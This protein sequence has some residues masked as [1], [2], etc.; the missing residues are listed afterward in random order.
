MKKSGYPLEREARPG[1]GQ[2]RGK[3]SWAL[4]PPDKL[5]QQTHENND[6]PPCRAL[7]TLQSHEQTH[8]CGFR[9]SGVK[10]YFGLNLGSA[11]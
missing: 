3:L 4:I 9:V 10:S 2:R 6:R 11:I 8:G 5:P 1:P 7:A